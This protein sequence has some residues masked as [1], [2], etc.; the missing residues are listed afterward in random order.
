MR[1]RTDELQCLCFLKKTYGSEYSE[2]NIAI[3]RSVH[4]AEKSDTSTKRA[5][6][7]VLSCPNNRVCNEFSASGAASVERFTNLLVKLIVLH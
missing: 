2:G 3:R 7:G 5:R 6:N 1:Y 4:I